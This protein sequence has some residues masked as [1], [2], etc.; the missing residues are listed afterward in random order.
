MPT[1]EELEK[2]SK[3][4]SNTE[5]DKKTVAQL[6]ELIQAK[7]A[8]NIRINP[9]GS[10]VN[11]ITEL[12]AEVSR[13][14]TAN[15][16]LV[17]RERQLRDALE[18]AKKAWRINCVHQIGAVCPVDEALATPPSELGKRVEA[19]EKVVE[20]TRISCACG[21]RGNSLRTHPHVSW[22]PVGIALE[23]L[24]ALSGGKA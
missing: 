24:D 14:T 23:N 21:A 19:M 16:E 10:I 15:L 5:P 17:E 4:F 18:H 13:L 9:D 1:P 7:G 11:K 2:M 8:E 22:C 20:A 3:D 6:Q 12:Q